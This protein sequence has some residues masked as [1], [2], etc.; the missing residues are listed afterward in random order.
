MIMLFIDPVYYYF[1]DW[2]LQ[3]DGC[4]TIFFRIF[5]ISLPRV[6]RIDSLVLFYQCAFQTKFEINFQYPNALKAYEIFISI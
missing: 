3:L 1:T 5:L 2:N 4:N 6:T